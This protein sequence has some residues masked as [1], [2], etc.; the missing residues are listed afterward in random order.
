V[1]AV[2]IIVGLLAV[3]F[4]PARIVRAMRHDYL[5]RGYGMGRCKRAMLALRNIFSL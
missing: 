5:A 3:F 4:L 1:N 2:I